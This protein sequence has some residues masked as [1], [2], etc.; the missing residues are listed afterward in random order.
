MV[1]IVSIVLM[2]VIAHDID[3]KFRVGYLFEC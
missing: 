2:A 1:V 3:R